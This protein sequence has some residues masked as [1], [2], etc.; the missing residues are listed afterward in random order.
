LIFLVLFVSRQ[1]EYNDDTGSC[2][3][4]NARGLLYKVFIA[5][6]LALIR[7]HRGETIEPRLKNTLITP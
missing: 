2:M 1:K 5:K 6:T 4:P 3:H 7:N